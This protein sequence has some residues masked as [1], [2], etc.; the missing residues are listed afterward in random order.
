MT[1]PATHT[2]SQPVGLRLARL[3]LAVALVA[4]V[5]VAGI[6]LFRPAPQ[7]PPGSTSPEAG[8]AR[9]MQVHHAQAVEMAFLIRDRSDDPVIRAMAYDIA[10]AQQQQIGQMYAWLQLWGVP[11]TGVAEPM[12]WMSGMDHTGMSG[13]RMNVNTTAG[14]RMPG[15]ATDAQLERLR[16]TEGVSAERLW[17]RLMIAH[18]EAGV[19]MARA[20]LD[21]TTTPA[22]R[23]LAR[24]VVVSQRSEIDQMRQ[25][26]AQRRGATS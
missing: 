26:L 19:D 24:S 7:A 14:G 22:V 21:L 18:H 17:L 16:N 13:M 15:M 3:A 25:L 1:S 6:A 10:T 5:T 9:D 8:F 2:E 23:A 11:Q 12:E 20:A 4:L